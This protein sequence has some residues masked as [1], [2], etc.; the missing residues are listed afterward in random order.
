MSLDDPASQDHL[1]DSLHRLKL[2]QDQRDAVPDQPLPDAD[3]PRAEASAAAARHGGPS[4][5]IREG[6]GFR[7]LSGISTPLYTSK[8]VARVGTP[9]VDSNGLGW[10]GEH[11]PCPSRLRG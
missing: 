10:P 6:Y 8:A 3:S 9:L 2:A 11:A 5:Q 7:P 1:S 4:P